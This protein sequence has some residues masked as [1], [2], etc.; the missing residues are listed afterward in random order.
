LQKTVRYFI[1]ECCAGLVE[2]LV[3]TLGT[4]ILGQGV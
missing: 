4:R 1:A 2:K 3:D